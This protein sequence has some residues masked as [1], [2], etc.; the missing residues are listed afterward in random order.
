MADIKQAANW[1]ADGN[2]VR[3]S[4]WGPGVYYNNSGYGRIYL[5]WGDGG[6]DSNV[7]HLLTGDLLSEEWEIAE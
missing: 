3:L 4:S 5:H 1:L 7:L 2:N 6:E